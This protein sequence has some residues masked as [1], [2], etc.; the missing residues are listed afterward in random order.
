MSISLQFTGALLIMCGLAVSC[1]P[2]SA[3]TRKP[4]IFYVSAQ[5]NDTNDGKSP[6][7]AWRTI[8]HMNKMQLCPGDSILFKGGESFTGNLLITDSGTATAFITIGSYGKGAATILGGDAYAI[9]LRNCQYINV[10]DLILLGSGVKP[11]GDTTNT[12]QGLDI[13]S[14]VTEGKPW[15]SIHVDK[16]TVSGFRDGI[17]L[18][19]PIGTQK[20][21][22]YNDVRVTNCTIKECLFG[23]FYCWGAE[24]TS[25]APWQ[26]PVGATLFTNC[27]LGGCTIYNIYGDPVGEPLLC[28]PVA[29][30]NATSFL[31][32]RNTIHHCG[33]AQSTQASQGGV[34]GV[35][36]VEC[37]KLVCQFNECHHIVSKL[38][39]D[40]CAF[41][42]DGGCTDCKLQY[43]YS[44]DNDGAGFQTG[45]FVGS[46]PTTGVT[47]RYNISENDAKK[48]PDHSGG[49]MTWGSITGDI[50]Q[51]TVFIS[52]GTDGKPAAF[53]GMGS[54][55]SVRNNIFMVNHDGDIM[56]VFNAGYTFQNN[57]Y[58]RTA[59]DFRIRY[60]DAEYANLSAWQK[61]TGQEMLNGATVGIYADPQ[62]R[63]PGDA[64]NIDDANKLSTLTAY[65]LIPTS[66]LAGKGLNLH[67]VF[68]VAPGP[69]DFH[70][71]SLH[72]GDTCNIGAVER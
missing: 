16:L 65:D 5:G 50:Y 55:V 38:R 8:D 14:D 51:N 37:A 71:A 60:A 31:I 7:K 12:A 45:T 10:R 53:L 34:A 9:R 41:D 27:Y 59:G 66:P 26:F 6:R 2:I 58:Y 19:T 13:F 18:H 68:D 29:I 4:T 28:F 44:H 72:I 54:G 30:I 49:I 42:I 20:V 3:E 69:C 21:V 56:N 57:G 67:K 47:I 33:Q 22:G 36:F 25:G 62:F 70:G 40:G 11:N 15:Q 46:G 24:K 39:Y 1:V 23:G 32:E 61:A 35:G 52:T 64:G 17:V 63:A 43:N 48:N